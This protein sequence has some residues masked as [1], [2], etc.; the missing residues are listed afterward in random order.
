MWCE[1][2]CNRPNSTSCV[3]NI[4][5]RTCFFFFGEGDATRNSEIGIWYLR[6]ANENV[7]HFVPQIIYLLLFI[8]RKHF[9]LLQF[10]IC[11]RRNSISRSLWFN[12]NRRACSFNSGH[13]VHRTSNNNKIAKMSC[14]QLPAREIGKIRKK[15]NV[16][17]YSSRYTHFRPRPLPPSSSYLFMPG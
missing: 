4:L 5:T 2:V 12:S 1:Y 7:K 11:T 6:A 15:L 14:S 16:P 17:I 13:A 8:C 10:I 3:P 9:S